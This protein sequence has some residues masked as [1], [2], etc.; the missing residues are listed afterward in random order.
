M[1]IRNY[2]L[3]ARNL[4][5]TLT[6]VFLAIFAEV[7]N[8]TEASVNRQVFSLINAGIGQVV[9]AGGL[10]RA[11]SDTPNLLWN[12]RLLNGSSASATAQPTTSFDWNS[13]W[14]NF[15]EFINQFLGQYLPSPD[16]PL[17]TPTP[18]P[19]TTPTAEPAP[20]PTEPPHTGPDPTSEPTTEPTSEPTDIR[21]H[22]GTDIRA[23]Y[24][25]D[26]CA[27]SSTNGTT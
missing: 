16:T 1:C 6:I 25:T 18:A 15:W 7:G 10:T 21:A 12:L 2:L 11:D 8:C 23:R 27:D 4:L 20:E 22:Y 5:T 24:G 14:E 26:V 19:A 3:A 9:D 17:P 13:W